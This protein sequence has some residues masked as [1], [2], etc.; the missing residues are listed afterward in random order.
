MRYAHVKLTL[1]SQTEIDHSSMDSMGRAISKMLLHLSSSLHMS[2]SAH[3]VGNSAYL[4]ESKDADTMRNGG[5]SLGPGRCS[6]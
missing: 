3:S 1:T 4:R 6:L 5:V 2:F